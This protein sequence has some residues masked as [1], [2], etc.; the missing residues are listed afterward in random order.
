[1]SIVQLGCLDGT[2]SEEVFDSAST[3]P[4]ATGLYSS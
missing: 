4:I 1:M 3:D 2:E